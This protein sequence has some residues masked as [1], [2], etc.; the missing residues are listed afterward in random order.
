MP[1][2]KRPSLATAAAPALALTLVWLVADLTDGVVL[3]IDPLLDTLLVCMAL[4][5]GAAAG[6]LKVGQS[7]LLQA[8]SARTMCKDRCV[9]V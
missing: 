4:C 5:A 7:I 9:A 8:D 3:L 1:K 2:V 6:C